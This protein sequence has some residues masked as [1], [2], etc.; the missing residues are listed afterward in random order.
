MLE[1][2]TG[3]VQ[4]PMNISQTSFRNNRFNILQSHQPENL[5]VV[6]LLEAVIAN[7]GVAIASSPRYGE[8]FEAFNAEDVVSAE[9]KVVGRNEWL[10]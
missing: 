8:S 9:R 4:L 5:L 10:Q 3:T 6:S 1:A 2:L 7:E